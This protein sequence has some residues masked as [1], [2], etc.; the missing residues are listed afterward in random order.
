MVADG[1]V[2]A[3]DTAEGAAAEKNGAASARA[4][5]AGF[6]PKMRRRAGNHGQ[7]A[8]V[9]KPSTRGLIAQGIAFA[10]TEIT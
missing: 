1:F 8:H 5:D 6:L 7:R 2:L 9:A 4:A 3:K 10:G